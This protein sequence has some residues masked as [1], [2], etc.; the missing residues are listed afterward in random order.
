VAIDR[1]AAGT[2]SSA[3]PQ[4]RVVPS[5]TSAAEER[6]GDDMKAQST[7][8]PRV[9]AV[10]T[11]H[12]RRNVTL[13]SL[14]SLFSQASRGD[15]PALAAVVVDDGSTDG[16]GEAIRAEFPAA[17]VVTA[18][19]T[20]FWARGMELAESHAI[21]ERPEFVLWLNDDVVLDDSALER[22]LDTSAS[23]PDTIVVG[24]LVDPVTGALT[25]SG[26]RR[27]RW[28][29]LRTSLVEPGDRPL[30]ADTFNGNVVLVPRSVYER[31]GPIDGGFSHS[32]ADFDYG[33]RARAA[34]ARI[35][36]APGTHGTCS[37]ARPPHF[38]DPKLSL[39]ERWRLIQS[40]KGLPMGSHARYL[41]RHGGL[42]W[43]L[44]W[45]VPY[46]KLT[47]GALR[48]VSRRKKREVA[49]ESNRRGGSSP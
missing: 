5:T 46:V 12:N 27:S 38:E 26:V 36:V 23:T 7:T 47:L 31:V 14:R 4:C 33:F 6:G 44:F 1:R 29:P 28:H 45:A 8:R 25:Y 11:C 37:R 3:P 22:L 41:R 16:T 17:R 30:E 34:G 19:G 40:P 48:S 18:D 9:V 2:V 15:A 32:Q 42:L 13:R 10:L 24:A 39:R 20:L 21:A 43:P 35:V 49:T